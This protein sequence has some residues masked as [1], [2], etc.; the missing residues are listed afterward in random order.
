VRIHRNDFNCIVS[1]GAASS[2]TVF[3]GKMG[4][5]E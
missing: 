3:L 4:A 2:G 1:Q 5:G